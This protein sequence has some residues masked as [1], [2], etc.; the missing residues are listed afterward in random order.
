[1]TGLSG[2]AGPDFRALFESAPGLFLV[3]S[4]ELEILAVSDAYLKAT[5]TERDAI[6]NRG[7]FDVFPDNPDDPGAT[8]ATNLRS[9]LD[10]VRQGLAADVMAVQKYDIRGPDGRFEE[11]HWK[12]VNSPVLSAD[13]ALA[14]I[15]HRVEDV[16]EDR[17]RMVFEDAP[18]GMALE[19]LAPPT[20]GR[21]LRVNRA[22][23][24]LTGYS[25][26]ELLHM[27]Y[28][29]VVHPDDVPY[30]DAALADLAAGR[31]NRHQVEKRYVR[32]D[33]TVIWALAAMSAARSGG[34]PLYTILHVED[35]TTRKRAETELA[36]AHARFAALVEHSSEA[37]VVQD[38]LG[39]NTSYA[40]PGLARVL[41]IT[42]A[43]VIDTNLRHLV[44]PDD[45]SATQEK[46]ARLAERLTTEVSYDCRMRHADGS[47]RHLE[48]TT[49]N[50]LHDPA[51]RSVVSNLH[52]VTDRV[53]ADTRLRQS[54]RLESLGQLA[55]GIAHDFNNL[56]GAILNYAEFVIEETELMPAVRADAVQIQVAAQR[57]AVL[58]RQLLTFARR[59]TIQFV[60]LDLNAVVTD[61]HNL[62]SRSIGE[63][64]QL[65][66]RPGQGVPTIY[67]DR[68]QI[69]QVLVNLAVNARD[70]MPA[71]GTLTIGTVAADLD[72]NYADQHPGIT[73]GRYTEL[74]VSDTGTGMAPEVVP[75]IFEPFFTTKP[76]GEGTGLGLATLYGIVR[77]AGGTVSVYSEEGIGTTFR[78]YLPTSGQP[79]L[80]DSRPTEYR[81]GDQPSTGSIFPGVQHP[82]DRREGDRPCHPFG[83]SGEVDG[84]PR[85][86]PL[87]EKT[88]P[89]GYYLEGQ[90]A[91]L[92]LPGKAGWAA[93]R[94]PDHGRWDLDIGPR[95][96]RHCPA[97]LL[98]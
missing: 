86:L 90:A 77:G 95:M 97:L 36:T 78:V 45:V 44:H 10:R 56:L 15:I 6:V 5:M 35:I 7:I 4:P 98:P 39:G 14:Y 54:E 88:L 52:D 28:W 81:G 93:A 91:K 64:V 55:G 92:V 89:V 46:M 72:A 40:T 75:H 80:G 87:D 62:L 30:T 16:T 24:D 69:E 19:S 58:T 57:A 42:P 21:Y 63:H 70:A 65:V 23:C 74:T 29:D 9:S 47:W 83:F 34:P 8:G 11:R 33:G 18:V 84:R 13:G 25:A 37:I 49:T 3:L 60:P 66:V 43:E 26:Q 79:A 2:P 12:P 73:P 32:A 53:E 61:I 22:F 38:A 94:E 31:I 82:G 48:V 96:I 41:G 51:V 59:Q 50:L 20:V 17:F 85:C 67:A 1:V 27:A 68:G 71:G 76:Q